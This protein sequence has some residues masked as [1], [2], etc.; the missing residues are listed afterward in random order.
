VHRIA[1]E[2]LEERRLL[3]VELISNADPSLISDSAGGDSLT[4]PYPGSS[5]SAD[6]RYIA[7]VSTAPNLVPATDVP[8]VYHQ[9]YR[10]DRLTGEMA[11]VSINSAGTTGGNSDSLSPVISADG[12]LI[13]F[14]SRASDLHPLDTGHLR[15]VFARDMS[16]GI[17]YL[18]SVNSAGTAS[19][20]N[21]S[22]GP[23]ISANGTVVAFVSDASDLQTLSDINF[24]RD[25]FARD[26]TSGTTY[27]VS[28]NCNGPQKLDH[29]IR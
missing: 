29:L 11:L 6:G 19:G 22:Y 23:V 10:Y 21:N 25:V 16:T 27:L 2:S 8:S 24:S 3:A 28:V 1:F 15:D 9:V 17:T 20:N 26:L 14:E 13:A 5:M 4:V 7:F 18:V 12:S